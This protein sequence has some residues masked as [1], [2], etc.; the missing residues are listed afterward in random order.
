[1]LLPVGENRFRHN[2]TDGVLR[3]DGSIHAGTPY[4]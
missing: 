3:M 4:L 1:M 2:G